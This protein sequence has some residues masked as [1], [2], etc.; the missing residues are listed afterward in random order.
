MDIIACAQCRSYYED[1]RDDLV[2]VADRF[3][4]SHETSR[5]AVIKMYLAGYHEAGHDLSKL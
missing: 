3:I 1:V 2:R 4:D 5:G